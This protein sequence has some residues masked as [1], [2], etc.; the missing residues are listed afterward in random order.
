MVEDEIFYL[1]KKVDDLRLRL[2]RERNWNDQRV[3]HPNWRKELKG[4]AEHLPRLPCPA[5]TTTTDECESRSSVASA[6]V[7]IRGKKKKTMFIQHN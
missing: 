4:G 6:S 5:T 1:E 7:I 2:Q 3:H